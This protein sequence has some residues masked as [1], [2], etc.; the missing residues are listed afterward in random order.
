MTLASI[1]VPEPVLTGDLTC[2]MS[3][4][5]GKDSTACALALREASVSFRMVFADTEWEA[6]ETYAHLDHLRE[7]L[8]EIHVVHGARG[9][10]VDVARR[11][12]GFPMRMGRW[13]T[14]DLKVYPIRKYHDAV[15]EETG[16]D[17]V[18]VIGIRA[19]ES[20]ARAKMA[21]WEDSDSWGG[22]VWRPILHWSVQ[23]VLAI[24][25]RHGVRVNELY[26]RGHS[27]VGCYPCIFANKEEIRLIAKHSPERI[28]QIRAVEGELTVE[29]ARRNLTGEGKF[30]HPRA[31]FFS[32]KETGVDSMPIDECVSWSKT[33]HGG[34]ALQLFEPDPTG[35][36]FRWG[37]C[38]PTDGDE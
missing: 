5:G 14:K 30:E 6:P 22:F 9:G 23:D 20:D 24:H 35:G 10:M 18:S 7:K 34:R 3:V 8:G 1:E 15:A 17:T 29:R 4:S 12:A 19:A 33:S 31:T 25:H 2:V 27:R 16:L 21:E 32:S 13:C 11:K 36:C 28:D 26:Q 37:M 38:E